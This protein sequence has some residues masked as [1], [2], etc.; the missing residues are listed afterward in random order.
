MISTLLI[1]C[2]NYYFASS[3]AVYAK[4][5]SSSGTYAG[6][7]TASFYVG[8]VG[9]RLVNGTL[10]QKHGAHKLMLISAGLCLAACFA[11]NFASIIIVL[12][13]FRVLHGAGY[14]IFSTASGTAASYMVPQSRIGEG[15]GYFTLGNVLAMAVGPSIALAIVSKNTISQFHYLFD[16]AAVICA[17]ALILV[18]FMKAGK[19]GNTESEP[20]GQKITDKELPKTFLGFEKGVVLPAI[21]SFLM[22]F[23]YSPVIVY[24]SVYGLHKGWGNIGIAFT[25]YALGLLASRLFTGRLS[26]RL[27][28]DC[29]M[30]PAYICGIISLCIIALCSA[31]WQLYLAMVVLGLCIG[32]YNPQINV[33]CI[34]RC[35]KERRG[36]AT[37]AFNWSVRPRAGSWKRRYRHIHRSFRIYF[38]LFK[39][40]LR[41]CSYLDHLHTSPF[42]YC[43]SQKKEPGGCACK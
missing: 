34:S 21:I 30:I 27:G 31:E 38:Y 12:L 1:S 16:T 23:S 15:M 22:T 10:V 35:T 2:A 39:R 28:S 43:L 41:V 36:T 26:D 7:I 14:S 13:L 24:L 4:I 29:V 11:H 40:C 17:A 42:K 32:A 3:M 37:A 25:M 9:M 20:S 5:I 6:L 8:S 33:F 19:K 18:C